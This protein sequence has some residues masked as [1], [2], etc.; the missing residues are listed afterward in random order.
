[1]V[2]QVWSC[3]IN[4]HPT[5]VSTQ[6]PFDDGHCRPVEQRCIGKLLIHPE[7]RV[8]YWSKELRNAVLIDE[9]LHPSSQFL[10]VSHLTR[11]I[12]HTHDKLLVVRRGNH[13][14][15][16][17]LLTLLSLC[18]TRITLVIEFPHP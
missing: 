13:C 16:H 4:N 1:M 15:I 17:V 3:C 14:A 8:V 11:L 5:R 12:Q 9:I 18:Q 10:G 7:Q 2:R 6:S